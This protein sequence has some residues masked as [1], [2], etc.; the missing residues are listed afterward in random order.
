MPGFNDPMG[1]GDPITATAPRSNPRFDWLLPLAMGTLS[2]AGQ[3]YTNQQNIGLSREQMAFQERMSSTAVQR[4]VED[5]KAAGLNPALA[6]ERTASSPG[7]ATTTVGDPISAGVH[8]AQ[9]AREVAASLKYLKVQTEAERNRG[10]QAASQDD[11]NQ[12]TANQ[13]RQRTKFE[14][15]FQP[16]EERLKNLTNILTASQIPGAERTAKFDK[17]PMGAVKPWVDMIFGTG[18]SATSILTGMRR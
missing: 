16:Y 2:T 12:A 18:K 6:Y 1:G 9:R 3:V 13:I 17:S 5:Y 14:Q 11:V 15:I 7:G 10:Q 8:S 4:S